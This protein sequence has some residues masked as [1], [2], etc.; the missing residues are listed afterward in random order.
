[1]LLA[2]DFSSGLRAEFV[3]AIAAAA[4]GDS[5]P[6]ERLVYLF[7]SASGEPEDFDSPLYYATS[8]EEE[9]FPW[10]RAAKANTRLA[11]ARRA[12]DALPSSTFAPFTVSNALEAGDIQGCAH[13]PSSLPAQPPDETP[14]PDVPA[15][16]LSGADDLR[17]PTANAVEVAAQIPD[18]QLLVVPYT[19]HS[20]LTDEPTECAVKALQAMFAPKPIKPCPPGPPP[21]SLQ[22]PPLP[23]LHLGLLSPV[24]GSHGLPGRTLHA[25]ALTL[26][27]T[28][29]QILLRLRNLSFSEALSLSAIRTGG[30]RAGWAEDGHGGLSFHDISYV[31]GVTVSGTIKAETV[32]LRIGGTGDAHGTLRLGAHHALV[33]DLG[34]SHVVLPANS[35]ASA[36]IVGVNAQAS[37]K[38]ADGRAASLAGV[39]GFARL[40]PWLQS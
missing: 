35:R 31:P 3:T 26:A 6:L 7:D 8:C 25:V 40:I 20:V 1:M 18:A 14:F 38:S 22:P 5:A 28:T 13:W 19:G 2:G 12:A 4:R 34:G 24:T 36:A 32:D 39:R 37:S 9:D 21:T 33:G 30:L 27:D 15:L 17:T 23:P 11:E 10:N 16:I 29:R